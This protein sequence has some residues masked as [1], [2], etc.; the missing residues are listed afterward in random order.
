MPLHSAGRDEDVS[1]SK[2]LDR[3]VFSRKCV[4]ACRSVML[5]VCLCSASPPT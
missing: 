2:M 1:G 5:A 4:F 3:S